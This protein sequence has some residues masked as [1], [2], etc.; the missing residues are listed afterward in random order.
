MNMEGATKHYYDFIPRKIVNQIL[1]EEK[2]CKAKQQCI[3]GFLQS[4]CLDKEDVQYTTMDKVDISRD[5]YSKLFKA[6][7]SRLKQSQVKAYIL[8][9]PSLVQKARQ[10]INERVMEMLGEPYHIHDTYHGQKRDLKFDEFN[11]IFFDLRTLQREMIKFYELEHS[12][13]N[14]VAIFVIK[15]DESDIVKNKKIER[16]S[17]TLMN[18]ALKPKDSKYFSVVQSEMCS[19]RRT[20]GGLVLLRSTVRISLY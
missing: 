19:Q 13:V 2:F 8:P 6:M 10:R 18:R 3:E 4:S 7:K 1:N 5:G 17:I 14:G 20:F 16:V 9:K 15:L 12:E 11:S